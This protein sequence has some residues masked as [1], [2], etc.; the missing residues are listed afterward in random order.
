VWKDPITGFKI[1]LER[2]SRKIT[3][4]S[5]NKRTPKGGGIVC[6]RNIKRIRM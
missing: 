5:N 1:P 4:N 6:E 3:D 2:I